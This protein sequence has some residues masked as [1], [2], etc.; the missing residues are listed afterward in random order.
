MV[1]EC[2]RKQDAMAQDVIHCLALVNGEMLIIT[3]P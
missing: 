2:V 1:R 3:T